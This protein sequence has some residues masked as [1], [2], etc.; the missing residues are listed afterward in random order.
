MASVCSEKM[1]APGEKSF[2][3]LEYHTSK[4]VVTVQ[5]AFRAK[6]AKDPP[7]CPRWPKGTDHCNSEE[8]RCTNVDACVART[9]ISYR[10]VPPC[11]HWCTHRSFLVI[12]KKVF[13][14]PMAVNSCIKVGPLGFLLI[15]VC[16][17]ALYKKNCFILRFRLCIIDYANS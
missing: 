9:W 15:S 2:C 17:L 11:H 7:T 8:Y 14:F 16:I 4:F 5:C 3:M 12:K 6:Y 1:A 10:C 13:R